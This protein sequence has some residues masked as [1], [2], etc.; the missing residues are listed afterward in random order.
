MSTRTLANNESYFN[1][2]FCAGKG[3]LISYLRRKVWA[4]SLTAGNSGTG[5]EMNRTH[6]SFV[7]TIALTKSGYANLDKV[8]SV[9]FRYLAMLRSLPPSERIFKEVSTMLIICNCAFRRANI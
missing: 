5:F 3:S 7:L 6:S 2:L 4:L 9:T 1:D 8:L